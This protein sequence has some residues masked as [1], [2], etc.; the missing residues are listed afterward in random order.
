[1]KRITF[2]DTEVSIETNRI[3]DYG[4][5]KVG[6]EALH[7]TSAREFQEFIRGEKF[8][9][10]HN[11]IHH[12]MKFLYQIIGRSSFE[13]FLNEWNVIDTLY[14]ST[15]LF[16]KK[17]YHAL[18]KDDKLQADELNNPLN[19]AKKSKEL[20]LDE[21]RAFYALPGALQRI[22]CGLLQDRA[23]FRAFFR[24]LDYK[25]HSDMIAYEIM[26][27]FKDKFCSNVN[28]NSFINEAPIELA[29]C[30]ALIQVE[31]E[32]S[33]TP[34]WVVMQ[35]PYVDHIMNRLRANPCVK[36]C[37]YCNDKLD[38]RK[39]LKTFFGYDA[40][41][42][43]DGIPLQEQAV[44]AAI[45]NKSLLAIFP[46]GGGKSITFQV[47]ALIAGKY[48]RGL[49]VVIS[50]LQSLMKDQVDNLEK[51]QIT[52]A[53]TINGL[54]D[55]IERAE[56]FRRVEEG[57]AS[58]LYISPELLRSRTIERLLL[59]RKI[60]RF[61]IDEAHC[62]S[63]WGHDFRVDY[64]YI[65]EFIRGLC[66]KKNLQDIIPVSCF[67]ATAKPNVI[68]DIKAYFKKNLN[69]EL[70]LYTAGSGRKNLKYTVIQKADK[71]KYNEIRNLLSYKKCPTIIY[72][73]RTARAKDLADRLTRDGYPARP[74]HGKMDKKE[75]S[76]NQDAFIRGDVD[77]MVATSAFG[78]GVDKKDIGMVIHHDISDS[79][80]NYVQEAGRAGRDQNISAEC[81][82]LF[83]DEDLNKHFMLLNQTKITLEEIQQIWK[84]IK[85][86][87]YKRSRMS[88]SALEIARAAGWDE[89]IENIEGRVKAAI[90]A[91]EDA[92]YIK[93]GF[94]IPHIY[95]DSI[96]ARN[97]ME[98]IDKIKK[99]GYFDDKEEQQAT[100]IIKNLIACRSRRSSNGEAAESR[101]DYI[102]DNLGI[103]KEQVLKIIQMLRDIRLLADAKD[104]TAFLPDGGAVKSMNI[105]HNYRE[106]EEFLLE[107]LSEEET[108]INLKEMNEK[109]EEAG[110]KRATPDKIRTLMNYW[111][112][113]DILNREVL[114]YSRNHVKLSLKNP[115]KII[116]KNMEKRWDIAEFILH[117]LD[118]TNDRNESHVE[119]SVLELRE[120]YDFEKQLL[121]LQASS[122]DIE[123]ALFYLSRINALNIEGGFLVAYN[124]ISIERL[125]KD[126]K[127]RYKLEDYRNLK[128]YYEQKTQMIHIVGEYA[129]KMLEDYQE[130]LQ[131]V[132]DYFQLEYSS[133]LRKYFK[134]TRTDEIARNLSPEKFRSLFGELSP[135]QLKIIND[136]KSRYI[137]VAAGPGSGKTKILVHKLASL[138]LMEDVK[139]EQLLM[140]TFSRAAATE[141]K[142]RLIN[143]IGNAANFIEIK[144]FH[145]Y[146]FDLLGRM[147]TIEASDNVIKEAVERINNNEAEPSRIA[148][149][150]LVIDEAQDMDE[151]EAAL[152]HAL[153]D[154]NPDMRVIAVGDDD[155]NI[156]SF[157]GSSSKHM[158][159]L[160]KLEGSRLY[161]LI[162]N[163]RSKPNL[164]YMTNIFA[165]SI[166]NRL[167]NQPIMPVQNDNGQIHIIQYKSS[168]LLIPA[169]LGMIERGIYGSTAILTKTN[170]EALQ[171]AAIIKKNGIRTRI[172]QSNDGFNLDHLIEIRYFVEQLK[173]TRETHIISDEQ[174]IYAKKQTIAKYEGSKNLPLCLRLFEDFEAVNP[175]Y[176]YASDFL[177]FIKE[178]KE[179]DFYDRNQGIV[180]VS[181]I[182]KSKGWEFDHVVILLSDYFLNSDENKRLLYVG[183]TR[184]KKSLAIHY[185]NN[186]FS[187]HKDYRYGT[188]EGLTYT[189]NDSDG[190]DSNYIVKQLRHKDVYLSYFYRVREMVE[191]IKSGDELTADNEG[192]I[193]SSGNRI[194][195]FSRYFKEELQ[196][197][198]KKGYNP[199][200]ARVDYILY[201]NEEDGEEVPVIFP[202]LELERYFQP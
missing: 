149:M 30:L 40:F 140:I 77:I 20:F 117:R 142:K 194:L 35:Y 152:I 56:A 106:L 105:L 187:I 78:M 16:P 107:E 139:Y 29:Y 202:V 183:M 118:E 17:P 143:L 160:L 6:G 89:R 4:A 23:E 133:F 167:K 170:E 164:V 123:G 180:T 37:N 22:Y 190:G 172:I 119:F 198:I 181:T 28:L 146:C 171:A 157:R 122:E 98:A 39:G 66:E 26:D 55:P 158:K 178:S 47:P 45:Y 129:K 114:P 132:D 113:K 46:T 196:Q 2:I 70:E 3:L 153:I 1:M 154:K 156:Y 79:L 62:F 179:E 120:A 95:A 7:T 5:V 200:R 65:A 111:V 134:G 27:Y 31:D 15:L 201:W 191:K 49:T 19:D 50:P 63:A 168:R 94:N 186:Y 58:I 147:G 93:R 21:V 84:V 121:M 32:Y 150:V 59:G 184:A 159:E 43:F 102:S 38:A 144:T 100:R 145:S 82:I 177:E 192:C 53:V 101:V 88:S 151:H 61:V 163:Y 34:R 148:K 135:S 116:R 73:S 81:Y 44:T 24:Y 189:Y 104:L 137:V 175:Q 85:D 64:L 76:E 51:H 96:R 138:L 115:K 188:I 67:T 195:Y 92:G 182:H 130:A 162:E 57:E 12:D 33:I 128:Q 155:Q 11:V 25:V 124:T 74:Y 69:I 97:A 125:E 103:P 127:I 176:K 199:K 18:V 90:A 174:W 169:V 41:R 72:V 141:F 197:Y 86:A 165:A 60:S 52:E 91:L 36:G 75:K 8:L 99:S 166:G 68:E 14:L 9:C 173:L 54:L 193:D 136:N 131:F 42:S 108:V 71:E 80:E 109:A 126:N 161:E 48:A 83:N 185:N 87:T 10:G 112:I 13:K 110:I